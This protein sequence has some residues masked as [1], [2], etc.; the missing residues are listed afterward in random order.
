MDAKNIE[1]RLEFTPNPN[2]LKYVADEAVLLPR[3]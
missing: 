3:R 2:A 1:I